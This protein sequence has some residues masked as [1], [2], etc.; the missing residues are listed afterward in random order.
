MYSILLK[1][2]GP[3]QSYGS[4]DTFEYRGTDYCPSKSAIIGLIASSMGYRREETDK[5]TELNSLKIASAIINHG[6]ILEDYHTAFKY[7][8]TGELERTYVTKR[9]YLADWNFLVLICHENKEYIEQIYS[10]L[11]N[12]YFFQSLGRRSCIAN[13]DMIINNMVFAK[14][15]IELII[16]YCKNNHAFDQDCVTVYADKDLLA[17]EDSQAIKGDL[18]KSFSTKNRAFGKR[19]EKIKTFN[20]TQNKEEK[21]NGWRKVLYNKTKNR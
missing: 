9:L 12:P 14:E 16:G 2:K 8:K 1:L 5:I 7:K 3:L 6:D 18:V 15:P 11:K 4:S 17:N 13:Y 10:A 21:C 19:V 20:L